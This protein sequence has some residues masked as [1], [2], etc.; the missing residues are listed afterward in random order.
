MQ[1]NKLEITGYHFKGLRQKPQIIVGLSSK[2]AKYLFTYGFVGNNQMQLVSIKYKKNGISNYTETTPE[3]YLG[4]GKALFYYIRFKYKGN[5]HISRLRL[6]N[7][8]QQI[9]QIPP[10]YLLD[11][12]S[13]I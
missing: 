8:L 11:S 6:L 3:P 12:L 10:K 2:N 5:R 7:N 13:V 9:Q 1:L 4:V